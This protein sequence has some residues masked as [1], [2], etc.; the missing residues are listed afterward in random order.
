MVVWSKYSNGLKWRGLGFSPSSLFEWTSPIQ[1][2]R[3]QSYLSGSL[4]LW[5]NPRLSLPRILCSPWKVS[6]PQPDRKTQAVCGSAR[7]RRTKFAYARF[8][9]GAQFEHKFQ[10]WFAKR[11]SWREA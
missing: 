5:G 2:Q 4:R 11:Y 6:F 3:L 10:L 1:K 8:R 7:V 9:K